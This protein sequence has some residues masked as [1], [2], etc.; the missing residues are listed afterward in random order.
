M[1]NSKRINEDLQH[2]ID[3]GDILMSYSGS[4]KLLGFDI[5]AD[6]LHSIGYGIKRETNDIKNVIEGKP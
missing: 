2:L 6:K 1:V 4:C 5:L 3:A